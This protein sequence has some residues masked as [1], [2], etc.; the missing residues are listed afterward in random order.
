MMMGRIAIVKIESITGRIILELEMLLFLHRLLH[1]CSH[2]PKQI[3]ALFLPIT[4]YPLQFLPHH[5]HL[6]Y[7]TNTNPKD[8]RPC[9]YNIIAANSMWV[10]AYLK[11]RGEE[12]RGEMIRGKGVAVPMLLLLL[13]GYKQKRKRRHPLF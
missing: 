5:T 12:R 1:C 8:P 6:T 7:L 4:A 10:E 3:P 13:L 11:R 2:S 9:L